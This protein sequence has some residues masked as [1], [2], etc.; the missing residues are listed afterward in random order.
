MSAVSTRMDSAKVGQ[1]KER[2]DSKYNKEKTCQPN[3]K[4]LNKIPKFRKFSDK[5]SEN[6]MDKERLS[7]LNSDCRFCGV[8][9][10]KYTCP[11]CGAAYCSL[12][13]YRDPDHEKCSENFYKGC[14][15][16]EMST[17]QHEDAEK[18]KAEA[19]NML[20]ALKREYEE[21]SQQNDETLDSD[22]EE[23]LAER[24]KTVDLDDVD[25]LWSV[26]TAE[27]RKD[28]ESQLEK[29]LVHDL[30]PSYEPWWS[31]PAKDIPLIEDC[32]SPNC[33]DP[34]SGVPDIPDEPPIQLPAK[35]RSDLVKFN[36]FN[37]LYAYALSTRLYGGQ[38]DLENAGEYVRL[39]KE[40]SG[41]LDPGK[42]SNFESS[43]LAIAAAKMA[44][45]EMLKSEVNEDFLNRVKNDVLVLLKGPAKGGK[46][47]SFYALAAV[48]DL[49]ASVK[50]ALK[51]GSSSKLEEDGNGN[52]VKTDLK[53]MVK[54]LDFYISWIMTESIFDTCYS[55]LSA[56][57]ID[58]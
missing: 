36:L 10:S 52:V 1:I 38:V 32:E 19:G 50:L 40:I 34:F 31:I 5:K 53:K 27:E 13:C 58:Q 43:S 6:K 41:N 7:Y 47:K 46:P 16:E 57:K 25:A 18:K 39:V 35:I 56:I 2:K 23:D 14:V 9:V 17:R 44:A 55:E 48:S 26:L 37:V 20:E 33:A 15:V 24:L 22:D 3:R 21:S 30:L 12:N 11:K 4:D 45:L 51:K 49:K 28:F 8:T 29:G 42:N 54:K